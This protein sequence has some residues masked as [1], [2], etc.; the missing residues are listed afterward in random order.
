M[1]G[2]GS[3]TC[4]VF[5]S[6]RT[7]ACNWWSPSELWNITE[8]WLLNLSVGGTLVLLLTSVKPL[9]SMYKSQGSTAIVDLCSCSLCS[10]Y[11]WTN[12]L[13]SYCHLPAT[14]NIITCCLYYE[15][16]II[17]TRLVGSIS[18]SPLTEQ[19]HKKNWKRKTPLLFFI[20]VN[21]NLQFVR[22]YKNTVLN[23]I[24][25]FWDTRNYDY[26]LL[27]CGLYLT[28]YETTRRHNP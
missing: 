2:L 12:V 3:L 15:W 6:H 5:S 26:I 21:R 11:T 19:L 13:G 4:N 7:N 8:R 27:G 16:D 18:S 17:C 10:V 20:L 28:S 23:E 14:W 25:D 22:I 9:I 1:N 24:W